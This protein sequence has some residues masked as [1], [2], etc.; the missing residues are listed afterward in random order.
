M[1]RAPRPTY[2]YIVRGPDGIQEVF[3]RLA[4]G[5]L[6]V[7]TETTGLDHFTDRVGALCFAAGETSAFF[8]KDAL[9]IAARWFSHQVRHRRRLAFFHGKFDMHMMRETFGIHIPYPVHDALI[10][11]QLIDNRGAPHPKFPG[12]YVGHH[13]KSLA[14]TYVDPRAEDAQQDLLDAIHDVTGKRN[15]A[16]IADWLVAPIRKAGRYGGRDPWY[17]LQLADQFLDRI[18]HWPQ[19][20]GYPSLMS[21]YETERWL[22]LALRDM[23]ERGIMA[24]T[25]FLEDWSRKVH[26][27]LLKSRDRLNRAVGREQLRNWD[28]RQDDFNWNSTQQVS[29]LFFDELE[30]EEVKGRSTAKRALLRM[31]HPLA[32][33]LLKYRGALKS[34]TAFAKTLLSK[35]KH[36]GAIHTRF[37]QN[38]NTGRMSASDPNLQ[39]QSR[40]SGVRAA[41]K[42]RKGLVLRSADYSQVEM[43]FAGHFSGEELLIDGFCNDPKFDTHAA[44]ARRMFSVKEPS[45][46]QRDRGKTMNFSMIYGAGEDAVAEG[47]IDKISWKE[48]RQS[49]I[50]LGYRPSRSE[51]PFRTLAHLLRTAVRESYPKL[52]KFTKD[53]EKLAKARG[54]VTDAFG[55]NRYLDSDETYKAMNSK[56][57]GSAAHKAK[58][59]LVDV[60]REL[61]L[62]TGELALLLQV[63]DD[64]I[65]ESEG[66]P[67]T[68]RRVLELLEDH[69]TFRVPI[70]ADLKGSAKNWQVKETIKIKR[71]AA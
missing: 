62:G 33:E 41:F 34:Y 69:H 2:H 25:V 23:E 26:R 20:D 45:A 48:A 44:L 32:V 54:F 27:Q 28:L 55:Y 42:P 58:A 35:V 57:Q 10:M 59:G 61:Q 38:V 50:E 51:S 19:P 43:R 30:F 46:P 15:K 70:V 18:R 68:D 22:L 17:T 9:P 47:L 14:R 6:G 8:C 39:Q 11:S 65:Y 12:Y 71:R 29:E 66:D 24:D 4:R 49:C 56:I 13:L 52:W 63:H 37:N 64:V 31:D 53:E 16:M 36:D 67:R 7:D 60:Y 40:D 21:L 3:D 5:L 1:K